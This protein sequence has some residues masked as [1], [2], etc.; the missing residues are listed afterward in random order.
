VLADLFHAIGGYR[1][2]AFVTTEIEA[3][4]WLQQHRGEWQLATLD[5]VLHDGSGFNLI[6]RCKAL[7]GGG[8]VIVLSDFV[9]PAIEQ[10][11]RGMGA[12]AVF[13]KADVKGLTSYL[14]GLAR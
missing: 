6:Q 10:R 12:D 1:I 14:E 3:T 8:H 9:T 11:C 13:S 4:A 2:A 5:L 7:D